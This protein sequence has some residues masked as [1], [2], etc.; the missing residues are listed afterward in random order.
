M[1]NDPSD[2]LPR[3]EANQLQIQWY[4]QSAF[5]LTSPQATVV[6]DPFGDISAL[7]SRG[8]QFDYPPI[9]DVSA[10]L[11]LITHEHGDHNAHDVV[12]GDPPVLRSTAGRLDSPIGEVTAVASEHDPAAGT[13]RGPNTI[14]VFELDGIRVAH[15]GDLGQRYLRD[16]QVEAIGPIDLL[17]IPVG[18]GPTIDAAQAAAVVGQLAPRW[19]VPM[20]YRTSRVNFLEPVDP[21]LERVANVHRHPESQFELGALGRTERPLVV[22]PEAP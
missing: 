19:V 15:L 5:R 7:T 20:H 4:G 6:I 18:G 14:F 3:S 9:A 8:I 21:F 22:V 12:E 1:M 17:M 10:D 16:E 13:Q 2:V 11:V